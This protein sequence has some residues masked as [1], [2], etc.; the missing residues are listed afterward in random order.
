MLEVSASKLFS[1]EEVKFLVNETDSV[2][3]FTKQIESKFNMPF[4]SF[5]D[6]ENR[7][8]I[9]HYD[10]DYDN[11]LCPTLLRKNALLEKTGCV[12]E[13]KSV[14]IFVNSYIGI[15]TF[16]VTLLLKHDNESNNIHVRVA[17]NES[18]FSLVSWMAHFLGLKFPIKLFQSLEHK[19]EMKIDFT[20][21]GQF[22]QSN[23]SPSATFVAKFENEE[24]FS[25]AVKQINEKINSSNKYTLKTSSALEEMKN[26]HPCEKCNLLLRECTSP[27][28]PWRNTSYSTS[29]IVE[30]KILN[31]KMNGEDENGEKVLNFIKQVLIPNSSNTFHLFVEGSYLSTYY[32]KLI[33]DTNLRNGSKIILIFL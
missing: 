24:D 27:F 10:Y 32:N 9:R 23:C 13:D 20:T 1:G 26:Y 12:K 21:L 19:N 30:S 6:K 29:R 25:Y 5:I 8:D 15:D 22:F 16:T 28:C 4:K 3:K 33:S 2:E 11:T 18:V 14:D 7:K 31:Y 17:S